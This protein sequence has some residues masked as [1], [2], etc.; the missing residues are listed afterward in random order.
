M[1]YEIEL[2]N[3]DHEYRFEYDSGYGVIGGD[4]L[5]EVEPLFTDE[6]FDAHNLTGSISQYGN[7]H[8]LTGAKVLQATFYAIGNNGVELGEHELT[9]VDLDALGIDE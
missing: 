8:V 1:S 9:Q 5:L 2:L 3:S 6:S 7:T 4:I